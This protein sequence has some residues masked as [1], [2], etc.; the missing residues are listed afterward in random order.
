MSMVDVF[1]MNALLKATSEG[2]RLVLVGDA[3]QL[4]PIGGD[5]AFLTGEGVMRLTQIMRQQENNPKPFFSF[6]CSCK[7]FLGAFVL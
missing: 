7:N 6:F 2:T 1:L 4:P 5:P 3:N